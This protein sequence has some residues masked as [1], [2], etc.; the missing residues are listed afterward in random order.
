MSLVIAALYAKHTFFGLMALATLLVALAARKGGRLHRR[1][2]F[3]NLFAM[4]LVLVSATGLAAFVLWRGPVVQQT[5]AWALLLL[6]VLLTE[7][8]V[9]GMRVLKW[10]KPEHVRA[11]DRWLTRATGL[12]GLAGLFGGL[13]GG[14]GALPGLIG[15]A[16][17][18]TAISHNRQQGDPPR[19]KARLAAHRGSLQ[20]A[21][22]GIVTA[23]GVVHW[24]TIMPPG[25]PDD[26]RAPEAPQAPASGTRHAPDVDVRGAHEEPL[27]RDVDEPR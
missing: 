14:G 18:L 26:T 5:R 10:R 2:G 3:V 17:L 23:L 11:G 7:L 8:L 22:L 24:E 4:T 27:R 15:F 9:F 12:A 20:A 6:V 19:A 21:T 16:A 1:A 13:F 25:P